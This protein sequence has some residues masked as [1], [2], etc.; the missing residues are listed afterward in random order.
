MSNTIDA[1]QRQHPP[2][3]QGL[4]RGLIRGVIIGGVAGAVLGVGW[5][6]DLE[7]LIDF[8]GRPPLG[9]GS[10]RGPLEMGVFGAFLGAILCMP[11][12]A[13]LGMVRSRR[14]RARLLDEHRPL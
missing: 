3:K 11:V 14:C 9:R 2:W 12:G 10:F 8:L 7:L 6:A 5:M 1:L 4:R 13:I